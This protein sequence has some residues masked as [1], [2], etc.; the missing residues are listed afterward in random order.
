MA[1][2]RE[3]ERERNRDRQKQRDRDIFFVNNLYNQQHNVT[4]RGRGNGNNDIAANKQTKTNE[5]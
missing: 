5:K 2:E 4:S 1:K 3:R